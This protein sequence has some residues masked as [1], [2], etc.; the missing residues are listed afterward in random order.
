MKKIIL[1]AAV[2][3][4]S[5]SVQAQS[6]SN[7]NSGPG[8]RVRPFVGLGLTWGGDKLDSVE[9]EDG[10]STSI[11]AGGLVDVKAGVDVHF[12]SP[13]SAQISVGY[14]FQTIRGET[15]YGD[16]G[17]KTFDRYPVEVLGHWD[18]ND[19]WRIGGGLRWSQNAKFSS[20]GALDVGNVEFESSTGA[21]IEGEYFMTPAIAL[22]LRAVHEKF[23]L[24]GYSTAP[25]YDGSHVGFYISYYFN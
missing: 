8:V 17:R 4:L 10:H 9:F 6:D 11:R 21:V 24:K 22:K 19:Q 16:D 12:D 15:R 7:A 23:T 14:H 25:E 1:A 20:N 3:A 2:L 13:F 18:L 5:A